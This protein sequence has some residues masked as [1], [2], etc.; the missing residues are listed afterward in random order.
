MQG[1]TRKGISVQLIVVAS[2][3]AKF[4]SSSAWPWNLIAAKNH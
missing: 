4:N 1:S 3:V 2:T